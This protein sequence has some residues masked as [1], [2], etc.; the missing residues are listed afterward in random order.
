MKSFLSDCREAWN[1]RKG[2]MAIQCKIFQKK[3]LLSIRSHLPE[4]PKEI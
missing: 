3:L 4:E 1:R 2:F